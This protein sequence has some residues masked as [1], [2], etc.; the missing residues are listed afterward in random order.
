MGAKGEFRQTVAVSASRPAVVRIGKV[1]APGEA[2]AVFLEAD[3]LAYSGKNAE[4]APL[5]ERAIALKGGGY[6]AAEIGLARAYLATKQTDKATA[7]I[8]AVLEASP[9]NAEALAVS[10]NILRDRG[11]YEEAAEAY[12]K[13]ITIA[14]KSTPEAHT[15]LAILLEERG[16]HENAIANFRL[17]IAQNADA[18]PILYQLLGQSLE[19][20]GR[21]D[22][23][24]A[25]YRGYLALAPN[26]ALA[27]A[28]RSI[29]EQLRSA[30]ADA[31]AEE[32]DVNPFARPQP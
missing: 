4:A 6:P 16:D 18:E 15:G 19:Q 8:N 11:F 21:K 9:Q 5:F 31:P 23:A 27:P 3:D 1:A 13:A 14:P 30:D 20:A 28:V 12:R 24:I 26:G 25:A 29:V 2:E 10:A 17:A 32:G 22:E 7:A